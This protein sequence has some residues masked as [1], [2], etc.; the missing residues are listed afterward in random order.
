MTRPNRP[1]RRSIW[2]T[3][4]CRHR[5]L[6]DPDM[7]PAQRFVTNWRARSSRGPGWSSTAR[8]HAYDGFTGIIRN[9]RHRP[10]DRHLGDF[11]FAGTRFFQTMKT[12]CISR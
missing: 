11:D 3:G 4:I 9:W 10:G 1:G 7:T 2:T 5:L 12:N 6:R 8:R